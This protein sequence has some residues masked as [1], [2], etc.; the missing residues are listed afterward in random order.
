MKLFRNTFFTEHL[1]ATA[2]VVLYF[3]IKKR[4]KCPNRMVCVH[5]DWVLDYQMLS[6]PIQKSVKLTELWVGSLGVRFEVGGVK[7]PLSKIR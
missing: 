4:K 3:Q 5:I 1:Q 2:P 6:K 7:L